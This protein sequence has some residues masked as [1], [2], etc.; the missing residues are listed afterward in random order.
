MKK[1]SMGVLTTAQTPGNS[2]TSTVTLKGASYV[3]GP[4]QSF[5]GGTRAGSKASKMK[6]SSV[7]S[8]NNVT[9]GSYIGGMTDIA[10]NIKGSFASAANTA[11]QR[12]YRNNNQSH[13]NGHSITSGKDLKMLS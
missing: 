7:A 13:K 8:R 4:V 12:S 11:T 6:S 9:S 1:L 3:R 10:P 2:G 5:G